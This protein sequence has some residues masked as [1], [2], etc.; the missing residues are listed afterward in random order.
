LI[1][2]FIPCSYGLIGRNGSG[3]TTLLREIAHY[4]LTGMGCNL[5]IFLS[6]Q[7]AGGILRG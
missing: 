6:Q 1:F 4:K 7:G 2:F 3:K 5:K